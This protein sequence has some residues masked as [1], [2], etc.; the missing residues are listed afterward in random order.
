MEHFLLLLQLLQIQHQFLQLQIFPVLL[1][2]DLLAS[3]NNI[4]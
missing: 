1:F 2:L 4:T 3:G